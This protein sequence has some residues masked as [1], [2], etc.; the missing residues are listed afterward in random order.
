MSKPPPLP[1]DDVWQRGIE[2]RATSVSAA[3]N[4]C[5]LSEGV[6]RSC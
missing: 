1:E 4:L 3:S 6:R 5:W 2:N